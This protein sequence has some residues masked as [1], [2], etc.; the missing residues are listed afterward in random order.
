MINAG[1][2]PLF[3]ARRMV[4]LAAEDIG[5]ADPGALPM[6]VSAHHAVQS[7]G[8]P[9]GRIPLSEAAIYLATAPK[10]NSAYRA[11]DEAMRDAERTSSLP[12]PLHL[13]NAVTSLMKDMGYG[14]GYQY[15]H[16]HEGHFTPTE[17]LPPGVGE[18]GYYTPSDQ[19]YEARVSER[20]ERWW[21]DRRSAG[22]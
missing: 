22:G 10:S 5:L 4:I 16:D 14:K 21:G 15:A 6:A 12:V 18:D 2:D 19:G 3:V 13:R 1:E 8:M 9:E 20:L 11:I 7:I 17:N